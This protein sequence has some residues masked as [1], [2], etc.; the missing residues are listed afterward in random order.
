M[1]ACNAYYYATR[2]PLG[3]AGDFVTA[4]E[5]SQMFGEL[6]GLALADI[7]ARAG[8]PAA[9]YVELG[10]GRGTLAADA[11]RAMA[12]RR[13]RLSSQRA[14]RKAARAGSR[15]LS[16]SAA[17]ASPVSQRV[18]TRIVRRSPGASESEKEA[19][20]GPIRS[21]AGSNLSRV[22]RRFPSRP[23]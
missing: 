8:Q 9:H 23:V 5:I 15:R 19:R 18:S 22:P 20:S 16:S 11:L 12:A 3:A 21:G 6:I 10:P 4:P 14:R 2:D 7:W 1:E 17:A 13:A